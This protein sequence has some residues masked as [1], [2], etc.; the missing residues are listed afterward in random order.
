MP[1]I[2]P[3]ELLLVGLIAL[4]VLGPKRLPEVGRSLGKGMREFRASLAGEGDD[5]E[6]EH[7][8]ELEKSRVAAQAGETEHQPAERPPS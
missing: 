1:N 8:R 6:R 3:M 4:I 7:E 2:G 5:E